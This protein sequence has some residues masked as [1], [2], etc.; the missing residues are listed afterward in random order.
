MRN[1]LLLQA[2]PKVYGTALIWGWLEIAFL[3]KPMLV[4]YLGGAMAVDLLT[5]LIKS[6]KMGQATK[7]SGFRKT[8]IKISTYV[9]TIIGV[10]LLA[11]L[12]SQLYPKLD[13]SSMVNITIGFLSF[14]ELYS[15]FENI[16][17]IDPDG[18]LS[19]Y[20][21]KPVLGFLKGRLDRNPFSNL[22]KEDKDD[23]TPPNPQA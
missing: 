3:P 9:S 8:V 4:F 18:A 16:F 6:W 2:H 15:V 12:M 20:I 11:N 14:I 23:T 1:F 13:Y 5:G 7:S 10:W 17:A 22:P 19:R 21:V